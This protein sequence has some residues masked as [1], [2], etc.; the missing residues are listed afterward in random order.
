MNESGY[1]VLKDIIQ[2]TLVKVSLLN[3]FKGMAENKPTSSPPQYLVFA[4][5]K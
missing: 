3:G 2:P 5:Y 1:Q 4:P